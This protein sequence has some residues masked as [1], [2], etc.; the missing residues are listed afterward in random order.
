M[1][2]DRLQR[3]RNTTVRAADR[4]HN[5]TFLRGTP[6]R[7][8]LTLENEGLDGLMLPVPDAAGLDNLGTLI[9]YAVRHAETTVAILAGK[10][11]SRCCITTAENGA[12][13]PEDLRQ[14]AFAR[15]TM[16]DGQS[17]SHRLGLLMYQWSSSPA[18]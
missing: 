16:L 9:E 8:V 7:P 6:V 12:G 15:A 4:R 3:S 11:Q 18:R 14:A 17:R 13:I 5:L 10:D 1:D 2:C